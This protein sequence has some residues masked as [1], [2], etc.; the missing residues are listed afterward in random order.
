MADIDYPGNYGPQDG[1]PESDGNAVGNLI[2]IA[3]ALTSLALVVGIGVWGYKLMMRDVSGVPVVRA[4]EGPMRVQPKDPG[5][6]AADYQGLAVNRIA[7]EGAAAEPPERVVLAPRPVALTDEDLPEAKLSPVAAEAPAS[8]QTMSDAEVAQLVDELTGKVKPIKVSARIEHPAPLA[9]GTG[10]KRV[11]ARVVASPASE[12]RP[13]V[14]DAPG[15][16]LSLRPMARPARKVPVE[17]RVAVKEPE[18]ALDVDPASLPK[19]TRLV[20]LG[21]Y[22][23]AEMAREAWGRFE[24]RFGDYMA[25]KRRVVEQASSGGRTFY[26]LRVMGF[27]DLADSRRF[28]AAL[29]AEGADCVPVTVR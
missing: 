12:P 11:A 6:E 21:A 18:V 20:Q 15:V 3:G 5:G 28:C 1:S 8:A 23:S 24:A 16:K 4:L 27:E 26:R 19:G 2:S 17:T 7:A 14:L 9:D 22:L 10:A 25:G 13:A 29:V